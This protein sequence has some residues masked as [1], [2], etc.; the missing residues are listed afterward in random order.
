MTLHA[1]VDTKDCGQVATTQGWSDFFTW[2]DDQ[3]Y[4]QLAH[5]V[6]HG[7]ATKLAELADAIELSI[8]KSNPPPDI[9]SIAR[10][11]QKIARE[12]PRGK[13]LIVSDGTGDTRGDDED[14]EDEDDDDEEDEYDDEEDED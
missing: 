8:A 6:Y 4:F 9:E 12:N 10:E 2:A 3:G 13:V 14:E 5:L 7:Y 11:I 1:I